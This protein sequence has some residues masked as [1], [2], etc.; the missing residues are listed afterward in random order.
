[1]NGRVDSA[2]GILTAADPPT[3]PRVLLPDAVPPRW[4][5][6]LV[7]AARGRRLGLIGDLA[8][9]DR[10]YAAAA[11]AA[12][13]HDVELLCAVKAS[14]RIEVLALALEHGLGFDIANAR[15]YA[16]ATAAADAA[17]A[18][19]REVRLSL[20][21]PALPMHERAGLYAA[22]RAGRIARWHC[23]TL[24]QLTELTEQC[25][26]TTVGIRVNLDG[27]DI[28]EG[29]PLWRPSR[30]G[31]RLDELAAARQ[32]AAARG[33]TLRWLHTHNASEVND[34]GSFVF[35]AEQIVAAARAH[36]LDL[37]SVDLGGGLLGEPTHEALGGFFAAVRRAAGP[38]VEVVLEPGRFWLTGCIS[39]VTQ[40]LEVKHTARHA[41]LVLDMGSM[42]H[43][44]WS[45]NLR[46]P[47]LARL[48]PG[49]GEPERQWRIC[50]RSCFEEDWLDEA[51]FVPVAADGAMP[52]A[53]DYLVLGNVS[54]YSVELACDFNGL[55]RAR[56]DLR[57]P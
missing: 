22:F 49:A 9:L 32:I 55:D 19:R 27:L 16:R 26:G 31:I 18:A 48:A 30:F 56:L 2:A 38:G 47:T 37:Q 7:H 52:E 46:I 8:A 24:A 35:A 34:T 33:C 53:G 1:V 43:L 14:T 57:W 21:S 28:P 6:V 45:D 29:M 44:Q 4:R 11:A 54:G 51:E 41:Y 23:D 17:A 36:G 42:N 13:E 10:R 12:A 50:G 25:P 3:A 40:V 15:E 20:T 5:D 39:L